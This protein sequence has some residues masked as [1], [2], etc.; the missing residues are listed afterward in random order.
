MTPT[1]VLSPKPLLMNSVH[2]VLS[3][4]NS[5]ILFLVFAIFSLFSSTPLQAGQD[6]EWVKMGEKKVNH[7]LDRDE[8]TVEKSANRYSAI[9]F[10]VARSSANIARCAIYFRNGKVKDVR[11]GQ[12]IAEGSQSRIIRFGAFG[13]RKVA[14]VVVWYDT[15]DDSDKRAVVEVW[16]RQ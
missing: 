6:P 5:R 2:C 7:K 11:M 16:G 9:Q 12:N 10:R 13:P 14:K 4:P 8:I 15:Q 1:I 3:T